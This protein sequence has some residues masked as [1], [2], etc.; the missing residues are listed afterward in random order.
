MGE[1]PLHNG[2]TASGFTLV[3]DMLIWFVLAILGPATHALYSNPSA[4]DT[5][6]GSPRPGRRLQWS[7]GTL[8]MRTDHLRAWQN[9]EPEEAR[10]PGQRVRAHLSTLG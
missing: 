7:A 10:L 6:L 5:G 3:Y 4:P 2:P 9:V 8:S 1:R